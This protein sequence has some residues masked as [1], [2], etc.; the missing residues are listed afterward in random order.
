[1]ENAPGVGGGLRSLEKSK[2]RELPATNQPVFRMLFLVRVCEPRRYPPC[3]SPST[4]GPQASRHIGTIDNSVAKG[5]RPGRCTSQ[6]G[7]TAGSPATISTLEIRE[8]GIG[9]LGCFGLPGSVLYSRGTMSGQDADS[10]F[11]SYIILAFSYPSLECYRVWAAQ[12]RM[13]CVPAVD[14]VFLPAAA[15]GRGRHSCQPNLAWGIDG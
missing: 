2:R 14:R 13:H 11:I 12:H 9:L 6:R 3:R 8:V 1:M 10:S 4:L 7:C 5:T 15:S